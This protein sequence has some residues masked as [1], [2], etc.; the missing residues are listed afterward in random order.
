MKVVTNLGLRGNKSARGRGRGKSHN[1]SCVGE[2]S[3][4]FFFLKVQ[5]N[6]L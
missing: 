1:G 3:L 4:C 2:R 5:S 6:Q